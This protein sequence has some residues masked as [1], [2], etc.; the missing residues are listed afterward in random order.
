MT[1]STREKTQVKNSFMFFEFYSQNKVALIFFFNLDELGL[2]LLTCD[3]NLAPSRRLS[4][5]V[6]K[7]S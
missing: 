1:C 7:L 2:T 6:L 4:S 5:Q 3:K